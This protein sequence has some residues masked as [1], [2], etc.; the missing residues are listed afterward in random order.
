[1]Y[2]TIYITTC[3]Y[4]IAWSFIKLSELEE[5]KNY[6]ENLLRPPFR[7]PNKFLLKNNRLENSFISLSVN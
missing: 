7:N 1:M 6:N 4:P 3:D 5:P 2:L